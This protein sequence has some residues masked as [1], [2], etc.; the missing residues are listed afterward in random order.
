MLISAFQ[1]NR[2]IQ[3]E[4]MCSIFEIK[5]LERIM[6]VLNSPLDLAAP[7]KRP[8]G[9]Q[10]LGNKSWQIIFCETSGS[11]GENQGDQYRRLYTERKAVNFPRET[12]ISFISKFPQF[13]FAISSTQILMRKS[14]YI[15][16][17]VDQLGLFGTLKL[18]LALQFIVTN[19]YFSVERTLT[20]ISAFQI[21]RA[22]I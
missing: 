11:C 4:L 5:K 6:E 14:L 10:Y 9:N 22:I 21:N 17:R 18:A 12:H 3:N 8:T 2:A 19:A 7:K 13:F 1:I 16:P 15:I 20:L